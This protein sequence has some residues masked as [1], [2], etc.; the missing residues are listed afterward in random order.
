[1]RSG[2]SQLAPFMRAVF[3]FCHMASSSFRDLF[4]VKEMV[5]CLA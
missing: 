5:F 2:A 1:M 4:V 3:S